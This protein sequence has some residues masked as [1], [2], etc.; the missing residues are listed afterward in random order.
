MHTAQHNK[1]ATEEKVNIT[2]YVLHVILDEERLFGSF[3]GNLA[4][5]VST[6]CSCHPQGMKTGVETR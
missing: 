4:S 3:D 1:I 6:I 5:H 2:C